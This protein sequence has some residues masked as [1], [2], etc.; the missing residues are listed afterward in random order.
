MVRKLQHADLVAK[1]SVSWI[2]VIAI[3]LGLIAFKSGPVPAWTVGMVTGSILLG[4]L[5]IAV[6]TYLVQYGV[7]HM[8][9]QRSAIILLFEL[10]AGAISQQLLTTETLTVREWTGGAIIVLSAYIASKRV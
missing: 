7:T 1:L 8:P 6:M 4:V 10:V 2:G 5:G 9:V 3:A